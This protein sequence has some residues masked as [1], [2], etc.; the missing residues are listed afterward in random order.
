[1][2]EGNQATEPNY[3]SP[4]HRAMF[5]HVAVQITCLSAAG[6]IA[7]CTLVASIFRVFSVGVSA[8]WVGLTL[9]PL[10]AS[11]GC[12]ASLAFCIASPSKSH[13]AA[14]RILACAAAVSA[15]FE[16]LSRFHGT[17]YR[18]QGLI[19]PAGA[20]ALSGA[21]PPFVAV[22]FV[23]LAL[24]IWLMRISRGI[25]SVVADCIAFLLGLVV[26]AMICAWLFR[27]THV[28]DSAYVDRTPPAQLCI[29]ALLI[30][31][32]FTIRAQYG[33][34][35]ILVGNGIGSRIARAIAPV[36][37]AL[38][39]IREAGRERIIRMHLLPEHSETAILAA[40][41]AMLSLGFL[42]LIAR[43]IR[44]MEQEIHGLSL[45]DELTGLYNLRGFRLLAEQALRL[46]Y[47]SQLPFS[48]LFVDLDGLK[49]INDSLG[50]AIGSAFL[51][52]TAGLLNATFRETD[53]I[54][55]IGGDE[56]A[57]AGQ[58]SRDGFSI[59]AQRL[60]D[61]AHQIR[62]EESGGK[63]LSLSLGFA[64]NEENQSPSLQDLLDEADLAMYED[65]RKKKRKTP[66]GKNSA[67]QA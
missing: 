4:S 20:H 27:V 31:V 38:P 64:T 52:E 54:A 10:I 22:T 28:F 46:A 42:I 61:Q 41:A 8:D 12:G 59:A 57:V 23:L 39:Y 55:R 7:A 11:I 25:G 62:I 35:D 32:A 13:I 44:R 5:R 19:D 2:R 40:T 6:I 67:V 34:F 65:K 49:D 9:N 26:L 48:I 30:L 14:A 47:R 51:V 1:M 18:F 45:R 21:M 24:L 17:A 15:F 53:V 63:P 43:H 29:L 33:V 37:L 16:L 58:F 60:K 3:F 36:L 50:H 56:F 66:K